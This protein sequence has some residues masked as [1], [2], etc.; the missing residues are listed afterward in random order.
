MGLLTGLRHKLFWK[1]LELCQ[2][3]NEN[4]AYIFKMHVGRSLEEFK[5]AKADLPVHFMIFNEELAWNINPYQII[6]THRSKP[7]KAFEKV[8][9]Y[10]V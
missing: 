2:D 1:N 8:Y 3:H 4:P 6:K 7:E 9:L 5:N 10:S